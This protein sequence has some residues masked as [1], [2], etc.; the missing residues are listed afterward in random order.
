MTKDPRPAQRHRCSRDRRERP[1]QLL[2]GPQRRQGGHRAQPERS[3]RPRASAPAGARP[4]GAAGNPLPSADPPPAH[5]FPDPLPDPSPLDPLSLPSHPPS[6]ARGRPRPPKG[7]P[8]QLE[9]SPAKSL[10]LRRVSPCLYRRAIRGAGK[11]D[12]NVDA[13]A[14]YD[15]GNGA[16][17]Y[18]GGGFATAGGIA[19][20]RIGRWSCVPSLFADGFESGDTSAW[21]STM[22]GP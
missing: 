4:R 15:D 17:L 3:R 12:G 20:S 2:R 21:S 18:A 19:S 13:L 1:P 16:A 5:V 8:S 9:R 22:G 6:R 10:V 7:T 14:M 11:A